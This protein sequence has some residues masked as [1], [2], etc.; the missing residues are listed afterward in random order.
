MQTH[1][2]THENV[3]VVVI[4]YIERRRRLFKTGDDDKSP[5]LVI[6]PIIIAMRKIQWRPITEKR[7]VRMSFFFFSVVLLFGRRICY[8]VGEMEESLVR[9]TGGHVLYIAASA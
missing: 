5:R 3:V 1:T 8:Y 2:H 7:A 6:I 4:S 9:S